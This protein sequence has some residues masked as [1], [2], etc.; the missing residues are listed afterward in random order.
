[1]V[2]LLKKFPKDKGQ[3]TAE[4]TENAKLKQIIIKRRKEGK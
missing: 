1:M 3:N 2:I 4:Y